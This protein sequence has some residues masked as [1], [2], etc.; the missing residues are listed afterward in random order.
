M[1][2]IVTAIGFEV[3]KPKPSIQEPIKSSTKWS[4]MKSVVGDCT[5]RK[6]PEG[7]SHEYCH[8]RNVPEVSK[9]LEEEQTKAGHMCKVFKLSD[10]GPT[11][12]SIMYAESQG[13]LGN[14]LLGYAM[15]SQLR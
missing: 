15:L 8:M 1:P 6:S 7:T 13:R 2:L 9:C 4:K 12:P 14:Q 10:F 5:T 3:H 11:T